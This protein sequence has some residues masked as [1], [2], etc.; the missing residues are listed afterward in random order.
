VIDIVWSFAP[1][2]CFMVADRFTSLY[3]AVIVGLVAG[4]IVLGRAFWKHKVHMLDVISPAYFAALGAVVWAVH[5]SDIDTWGRY[6]QAG[7][8]GLLTL[9]VFTSVLIRRPF[10]AAYAR[11]RVPQKYWSSPT[12]MATNR[13]LSIVWG[14]ALLVGF[15]S[16]IIAGATD[17][18][19]FVFRVLI[20]FGALL[21][22]M[23]YSQTQQTSAGPD[24]RTA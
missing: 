4:A 18:R 9:I 22:A 7:S 14:L 19:T 2:I 6:A 16:L 23:R 3:G 15:V 11:D 24:S 8:H 5:P 10:T 13:R 20:P 21:L 12:F 17:A 1:W